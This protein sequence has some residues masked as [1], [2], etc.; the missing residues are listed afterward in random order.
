MCREKRVVCDHANRICKGRSPSWLLL[1][2]EGK[3]GFRDYL[4][5]QKALVNFE[6][7]QLVQCENCQKQ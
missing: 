3:F 4:R 7:G 1:L 6:R 5:A 2:T